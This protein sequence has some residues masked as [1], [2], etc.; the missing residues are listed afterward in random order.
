LLNWRR[1]NP[2][3]SSNLVLSAKASS[4]SL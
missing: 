3:T 2:T 1:S 4:K